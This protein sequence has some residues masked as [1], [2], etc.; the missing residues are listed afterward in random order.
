MLVIKETLVSTLAPSDEAALKHITYA[1][2]PDGIE[3]Q[4]V[5]A[6]SGDVWEAWA[7]NGKT[8]EP[9][10]YSNF[11]FNSYAVDEQGITY[12]A[13]T[14]GI[15]V[16]EGTTDAGEAIHTCVIL[17][18]A[19]FGTLH[20]KRFRQ[21]YF[22]VVGAAP[23]VRAEVGNAGSSIPILHSKAVF[24]RSLMGVKW[25]FLIADFDELGQVELFPVVLTR[26]NARPV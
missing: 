26:R 17:S 20:Q 18:P 22:D 3:F 24:P 9:S 14:E 21:G 23:V 1:L 7:F 11:P 16:L 2:L 25:S 13:R 6:V 4:P 19:I 12:A 10:V 15:Y 5:S 8:F